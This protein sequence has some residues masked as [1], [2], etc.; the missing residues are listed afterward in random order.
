MYM[1]NDEESSTWRK[2]E[3]EDD[4]I[5]GKRKEEKVNDHR[6]LYGARGMYTH[7]SLSPARIKTGIENSDRWNTHT[8]TASQR[9]GKK[10][11]APSFLNT[12]SLFRR[13]R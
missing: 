11:A 12:Q 3:E 8:H 1:N 4:E 9:E 2:E 6:F 7:T 13:C 5:E 10:S